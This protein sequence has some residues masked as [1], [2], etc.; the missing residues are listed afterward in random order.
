VVC[1]CTLRGGRWHLIQIGRF[2]CLGGTVR[3]VQPREDQRKL[4]A[5]VVVDLERSMTSVQK[6]AG[7]LDNIAADQF[8][9]LSR[10]SRLRFGATQYTKKQTYYGSKIPP[11][12]AVLSRLA[13][14]FAY[15]T[16]NRTMIVV[17]YVIMWSCL[18]LGSHICRNVHYR[19]SY[20]TAPVTAAAA[21]LL[22]NPPSV[23][24]RSCTVPQA[25]QH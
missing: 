25:P 1:A 20:C 10:F 5:A 23:G 22:P 4:T 11:L 9:T 18:Q 13:C 21:G 8:V 15:G 14:L 17:Y 16:R 12:S 2:S 19:V 24:R 3:F 6:T 7:I